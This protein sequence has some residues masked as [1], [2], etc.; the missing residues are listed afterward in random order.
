MGRR[1]LELA[2]FSG[3][4]GFE[5]EACHVL[6]RTAAEGEDPELDAAH[7]HYERAAALAAELGMRP[8]VAHCHLGLGTLY[9][10]T[11]DGAKAQQHLLIATGMYRDMDMGVWL[12]KAEVTLKNLARIMREP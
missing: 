2:E 5:A 9:R 4:R 11:G 12:E 7:L 10:R 3:E 1:A 6:A 8:L